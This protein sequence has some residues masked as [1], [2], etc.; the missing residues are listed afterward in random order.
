M[1]TPLGESISGSTIYKLYLLYTQNAGP[2]VIENSKIN[3]KI[4]N[5]IRIAGCSYNDVIYP[6]GNST[7]THVN[8]PIRKK[9]F[10]VILF[11]IKPIIY[12][13]RTPKRGINKLSKFDFCTSLFVIW[14]KI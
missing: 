13:P 1:H 10:L 4:N 9:F 5:T 8:A 6:K 11:K 12:A 2:I 3:D 7:S 14:L